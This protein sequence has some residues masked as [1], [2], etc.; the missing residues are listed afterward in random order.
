[1]IG[2]QIDYAYGWKQSNR[3]IVT[4]LSGVTIGFMNWN[5]NSMFKEFDEVLAFKETN[6]NSSQGR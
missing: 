3:K 6:K 4:R 5:D 1:M 2:S